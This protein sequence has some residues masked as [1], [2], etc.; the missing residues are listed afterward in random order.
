[1]LRGSESAL[2]KREITGKRGVRFFR[3]R[4]REP[5]RPGSP[6][7]MKKLIKQSLQKADMKTG[8]VPKG[9]KEGRE[10]RSNESTVLGR[11]VEKLG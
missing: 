11:Q 5:Q 10:R 9:R 8:G 3:N 6:V 7:K 2:S 1:M 4:G